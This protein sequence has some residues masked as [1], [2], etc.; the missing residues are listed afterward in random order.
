MIWSKDVVSSKYVY[1][2][3]RHEIKIYNLT[4]FIQGNDPLFGWGPPGGYVFQK[5]YLEFFTCEEMVV[6][7][8]QVLGR[9]P[10]VN[11]QVIS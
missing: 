2:K 8:L 11:F 10:N 3:R 1:L 9:Y 4:I 5:A 6:A 7:L